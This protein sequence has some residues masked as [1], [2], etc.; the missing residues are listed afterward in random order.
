MKTQLVS[1]A[2]CILLGGAVTPRGVGALD[3]NVSIG[4]YPPPP[5]VVFERVPETV[6]VPGTQ[7][8]YVPR[9]SDYDLYR[10]GDRWYLNR[11]GYWYRAGTYRGPF[12]AL[13]PSRVPGVI[14]GLPAEYRRHPAHPHGGPPGQLKKG[15]GGGPPA[16]SSK[17]G[18][19]K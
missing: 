10:H 6:I 7:V 1:L 9:S 5:S 15:A 19:R 4:A 8:Y 3:I 12:S 17:G 11:N 2:A 16:H 13:E 18:K 14:I